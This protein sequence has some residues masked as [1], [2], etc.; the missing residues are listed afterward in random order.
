[1]KVCRRKLAG[2]EESLKHLEESTEDRPTRRLQVDDS[3]E[4]SWEDAPDKVLAPAFAA[5]LSLSCTSR[6]DLMEVK[7]SVSFCNYSNADSNR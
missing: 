3:V 2:T 5:C 1:M 7:S 4:A 6:R